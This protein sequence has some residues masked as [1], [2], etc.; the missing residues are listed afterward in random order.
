M[1]K[2]LALTIIDFIHAHVPIMNRIVPL[3]TFRYGAAG[4]INLVYNIVQYWFIYNYVLFQNDVDLG[5]VHI[6]APEFAWM[7][8]FVITF[9]T[10]FYLVRTLAFDKSTVRSRTQMFRYMIAVGIN[11]LINYFG[12]KLLID[13]WDFYPSIANAAIQI[14]TINV[15]FLF[16]KHFTFKA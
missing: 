6:P 15:S 9:F 3:Q 8:N 16:N 5:F 7:I 10:G 4:T 1:L 2:K 11:I 12:L 13:Y 14:V